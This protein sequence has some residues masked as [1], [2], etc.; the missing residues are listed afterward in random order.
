MTTATFLGMPAHAPRGRRPPA[1][2]QTFPVAARARRS[3]TRQLRRNIGDATATIRDKRAA[4]VAEVDDWEELRLAG[5][6]DQGRD[7]G[8]PRRHLL[9]G[10]RQTVTARGGTVHWARDASE[11]N[12][13][14]DRAGPSDRR[15]RG[16]QGQVDGHP[17]DRAQRGALAEAGIAAVRDRPGRAHRP[18]RPRHSRATSWCRRSTATGPRSARSSCARC[19]GVDPDLTDEPRQLADGRPG[20]PAPQ[21]PRAPRSRCPARTSRSPRP[22]RSSVVESEGNG[23]MCLTLPQTPHHRHGHREGRADAGATWRC[24][25]SCCRARRPASG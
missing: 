24:S 3:A 16:R 14:V 11:A 17:G 20:A 19:R 21:V 2:A 1:R 10:W 12:R 4:V 15:R 5:A 25:S 6:G 9:D 8:A 22:A 13:I 18:A 7:H 23:R